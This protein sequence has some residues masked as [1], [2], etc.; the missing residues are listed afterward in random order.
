MLV[1]HECKTE[2]ETGKEGG[3]CPVCGHPGGIEVKPPA[4]E[5]LKGKK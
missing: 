1:C 5:K 4:P 3:N 2:F